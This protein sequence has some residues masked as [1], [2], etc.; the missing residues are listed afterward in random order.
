MEA[1][2]LP[3]IEGSELLDTLAC[4]INED[5]NNMPEL[6]AGIYKYVD[7]EYLNSPLIDFI[8]EEFIYEGKW[9]CYY[10]TMDYPFDSILK[11]KSDNKIRFNRQIFTHHDQWN[12]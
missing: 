8:S 7:L 11:P 1:K 9:F 4:Q 12:I 5:I 6:S 2:V 3:I 10:S